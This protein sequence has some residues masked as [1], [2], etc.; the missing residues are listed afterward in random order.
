VAH[1]LT[2]QEFVEL[3]QANGRS[4]WCIAAAILGNR[5]LAD[6]VVQEAAV[7]GLEKLGDF[8]P[9]TCFRAWMGQIVRNI[10]RNRGRRRQREPRPTDDAR[11]LDGP[12]ASPPTVEDPPITRA[13]DLRAGQDQFDDEV[14][15]ALLSLGEHA[16]ACLLLRTVLDLPYREISAL[17]G[18]PEGTAMSHVHRARQEMRRRLTTPPAAPAARTKSRKAKRA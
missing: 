2:H 11:I 12:A 15:G 3:F 4:L 13:G 1:C 18:M 14:L 17:L 7:V 6:D 9:G 5:E 16:R 8:E 10:A